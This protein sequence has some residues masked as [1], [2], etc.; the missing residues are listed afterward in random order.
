M[1]VVSNTLLLQICCIQT[2][3]VFN[4]WEPHLYSLL[5]RTA[6]DLQG[7]SFSSEFGFSLLSRLPVNRCSLF[8]FFTSIPPC[9]KLPFFERALFSST[10]FFAK[11]LS[12]LLFPSCVLDLLLLG[13]HVLV[14]SNI[15]I[16][17]FG[18]QKRVLKFSGLYLG[19]LSMYALI[20]YPCLCWD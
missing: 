10:G 11:D 4:L 18:H 15:L 8:L 17:L 6:F 5:I 7:V 3:T 13:V 19:Q 20:M 2:L 9:I 12:C 14:I 16:K 1:L